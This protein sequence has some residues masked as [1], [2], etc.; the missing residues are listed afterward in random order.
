MA[1]FNFDDI[2]LDEGDDGIVWIEGLGF[3][4]ANE[5]T[6][7]EPMQSRKYEPPQYECTDDF[8]GGKYD[9]D[10]IPEVYEPEIIYAAPYNSQI[11]APAYENVITEWDPLL[12]PTPFDW[13]TDCCKIV[14]VPE[15]ITPEISAVPLPESSV[16]LVA[17]IALMVAKARQSKG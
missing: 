4:G 12:I 10:L 17:A 1:T 3:R 14:T 7:K 15:V 8:V 13:D 9:L 11:Y 6:Q 5:C 16:L 2:D